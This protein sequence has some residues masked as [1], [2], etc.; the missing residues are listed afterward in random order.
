MQKEI[1]LKEYTRL[2]TENK[3]LLEE[4]KAKNEFL[5]K[6]ISIATEQIHHFQDENIKLV[7]EIDELNPL[8]VTQ[9]EMEALFK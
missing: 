5:S 1:A 7:C 3:Q 8:I 9:A 6:N 2:I 4:L